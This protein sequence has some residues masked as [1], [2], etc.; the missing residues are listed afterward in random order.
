MS[1]L[2]KIGDLVGVSLNRHLYS[3]CV[4]SENQL[5]RKHGG[6]NTVLTNEVLG[7]YAGNRSSSITVIPADLR[8]LASPKDTSR[9]LV[10]P[11]GAIKKVNVYRAEQVFP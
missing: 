2:L 1:D 11:K 9:F 3:V 5:S 6:T 8:L 10:I 4:G 7:R